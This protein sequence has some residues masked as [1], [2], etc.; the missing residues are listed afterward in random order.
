MDALDPDNAPGVGTPVFNG[1]TGREGVIICEELH[2][3][4]RLLTIDLVET[5]PLLDY[6]NATGKLASELIVT[7]LGK[8]D[9][10]L[11]GI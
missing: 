4:N 3:I 7:Y 1:M 11:F 5:N 10:K 2:D 8:T 9:Y 6:R